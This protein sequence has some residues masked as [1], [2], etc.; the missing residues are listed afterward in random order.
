MSPAAS[1]PAHD[2]VGGVAGH[3]ALLQ[4]QAAPPS[5]ASQKQTVADGYLQP[6]KFEIVVIVETEQPLPPC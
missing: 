3:A 1:E 5:A 4:L 6:P 2:P